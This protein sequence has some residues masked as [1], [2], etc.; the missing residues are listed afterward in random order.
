MKSVTYDLS[1]I[2]RAIDEIHLRNTI[3]AKADS[4]ALWLPKLGWAA[5]GI[6]VGI[7]IA[8]WGFSSLKAYSQVDDSDRHRPKV[9]SSLTPNTQVRPDGEAITGEVVTDYAIFHSVSLQNGRIVTGWHYSSELQSEPDHQW[10]YLEQPN[11]DGTTTVTPKEKLREID[12]DLCQW[13][14]EGRS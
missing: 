9:A 4:R 1:L 8:L 13:F 7:A 12:L 10:C 6:G 2:E 14:D 3:K 11:D 5:V